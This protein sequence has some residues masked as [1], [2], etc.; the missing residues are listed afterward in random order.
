MYHATS[1]ENASDISNAGKLHTFKPWEGTEQ[2]AW[3]D[4]STEK[5]N[6]FTNTPEHTWQFA[7]EHGRPVLLRIPKGAHQFRKETTGDVYSTKPV[8]ADRI[9]GLTEDGQWVPLKEILGK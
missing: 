2:T 6:Y 4:G 8:P 5:R 9:E 7:P 3:P 1:A